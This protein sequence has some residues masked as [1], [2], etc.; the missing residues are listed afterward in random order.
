[1]WW[2]R[3]G[4]PVCELPGMD[5]VRNAARST[6]RLVLMEE[7]NPQTNSPECRC[8]V[9]LVGTQEINR[10]GGAGGEVLVQCRGSFDFE[11]RGFVSVVIL[12][13]VQTG[14]SRGSSVELDV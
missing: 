11:S 9:S 8:P 1:M 4:L 5:R 12:V 10:N 2:P 14:G 13:S 6:V 3:D 7:H